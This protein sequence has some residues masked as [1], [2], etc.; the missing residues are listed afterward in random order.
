MSQ[1][2][3]ASGSSA[4]KGHERIS[5]VKVKPATLKILGS[6]RGL[7]LAPVPPVVGAGLGIY[8]LVAG[9]DETRGEVQLVAF[10]GM[11]DPL[12]SRSLPLAFVASMIGCGDTA[13]V[14]GNRG[15]ELRLL[16]LE[17]D[18]V[19]AADIPLL[20]G[21]DLLLAPRL[22][23]EGDSWSILWIDRSGQLVVRGATKTSVSWNGLTLDLAVAGV[24]DGLLLLR[25]AGI[26]GHLELLHCE[27]GQ[28]DRRRVIA[29]SEQ[30]YSPQ[31]F[32][33]DDH[34][35]V[36]WL[37]R[38]AGAILA[39]NFGSDLSPLGSIKTLLSLVAP[40]TFR[41]LRGFYAGEARVAL[42]WQTEMPADSFSQ[43]GQPVSGLAQYVA[44]S[45]VA[46]LQLGIPIPI[47]HPGESFFTG[48]WVEDHLLVVSGGSPGLV[49]LKSA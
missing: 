12:S 44:L 13:Y 17:P 45:D 38:N 23:C 29:G 9:R 30:A 39:Q 4:V 1:S 14:L 22:F 3:I 36:I 5:E 15:P 18:G 41:W 11:G 20:A 7:P 27:A 48:G 46:A 10:D 33:L 37:S 32:W 24:P 40:Q 35:L 42:A 8:F 21:P 26:P 47:P 43:T 6:V 25:L 28:I 19:V 2:P 31:L 34:A 16:T 49:V